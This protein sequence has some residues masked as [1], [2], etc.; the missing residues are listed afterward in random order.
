MRIEEACGQNSTEMKAESEQSMLERKS[1]K[2]AL[3]E[4]T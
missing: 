1:Y 4:K 2:M 3:V